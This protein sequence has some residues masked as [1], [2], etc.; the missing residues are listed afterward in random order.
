MDILPAHL[1]KDSFRDSFKGLVAL[2]IIHDLP[3]G[4]SINNIISRTQVTMSLSI[5]STSIMLNARTSSSC[6]VPR[7]SFI[8]FFLFESVYQKFNSARGAIHI[9]IE[10]HRVRK[11]RQRHDHPI[12]C[13][14]HH[15]EI[16]LNTQMDTQ[17]RTPQ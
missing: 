7:R 13:Y 1:N 16:T 14:I 4:F 2:E 17:S 15:N 3:I 6:A 12:A 10:R 8:Y 11:G 9:E 5:S